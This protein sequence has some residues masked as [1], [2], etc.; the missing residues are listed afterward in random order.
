M[1]FFI[2]IVNF[3]DI[4]KVYKFGVLVGVIMNFFL[5]VKEGVKFEDCI[6]EIC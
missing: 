2:D 5:V 3:E 4:K 1:K 6:V